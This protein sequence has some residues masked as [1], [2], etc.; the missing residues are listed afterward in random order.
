MKTRSVGLMLLT[1]AVLGGLGW[2]G[3]GRL[4]PKPP[5]EAAA[6][7]VTIRTVAAERRDIPVWL[8]GVGNVQA[9]NTVTVRSRVEGQILQ[10]AYTEGQEIKEGDLLVQI[11]PRP[12][13]AA[14]AQVM[15]QRARNQVALRNAQLDVQRSEELAPRGFAPRQLLDTQRATASGLQAALAGD[16]AVIDAAQVQLG[17]TRIT[18]PIS[19]RTGVRLVDIGNIVRA[20]DTTG[21]VTLTQ[22]Q[23]ISATFGL[24]QDLL[25]RINARLAMGAGPLTVEAL[26]RNGSV[27]ARGEMLLVDN[28]IDVE[29]GTARIKA[30]F[31]N[32][33]NALWPGQFVTGRVLLETRADAVTLP[34]A[35]LQRGQ[36]SARFVFVV[37]PDNKAEVRP[38]RLGPAFEGMVVV[39]DG[40]AEGERVVVDGTYRLRRGTP[41]Q[42]EKPD[43]PQPPSA[44][45]GR[46]GAA[47]AATAP[48]GRQP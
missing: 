19:G 45:P 3:W 39:E 29:T 42:E 12:F 1:L 4:S 33:N 36:D 24:P 27:L 43:G 38:V 48:P 44:P 6:P 9:L 41:V 23:P 40:L 7:P 22:V 20:A 26:A 11:D 14:L 25:P 32:Q 18:A 13:E 35:A 34:A 28:Q 10:I 5:E 47:Q 46:P 16:E 21:L 15:A 31:P 8:P 37:G 30:T 2:F 17:Y